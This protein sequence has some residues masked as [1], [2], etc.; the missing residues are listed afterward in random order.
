MVKFCVGVAH[1]CTATAQ[2]FLLNS[3]SLKRLCSGLKVEMNLVP[4][5]VECEYCGIKR[6]FFLGG[7]FDMKSGNDAGNLEQAM[8]NWVY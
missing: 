5:T 8:L 6:D 2:D 1:G 3:F 4:L 7:V